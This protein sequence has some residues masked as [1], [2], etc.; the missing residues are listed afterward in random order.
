MQSTIPET[1][2][3]ER[4]TK[5]EEQIRNKQIRNKERKNKGLI[6]KKKTTETKDVGRYKQVTIINQR[7]TDATPRAGVSQLAAGGCRWLQ[8]ADAADW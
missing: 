7:Y 5:N 2:N 3:E 4:R 6:R 8:V 1:K